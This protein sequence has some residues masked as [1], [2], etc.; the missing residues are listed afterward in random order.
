MEE[1]RVL[2]S[3]S[4]GRKVPAVE[5]KD[6]GARY[7]GFRM[8]RWNVSAVL[9]ARGDILCG[10]FRLQERRVPTVN[11]NSS[12]RSGEGFERRRRRVSDVDVRGFRQLRRNCPAFLVETFCSR[13]FCLSVACLDVKVPET[14]VRPDLAPFVFC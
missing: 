8:Y 3:G 14:L 6:S 4:A 13:W 5:L 11:V 2:R 1:F 7:H 10:R 12:G 9:E